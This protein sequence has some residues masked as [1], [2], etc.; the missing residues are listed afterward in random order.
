MEIIPGVHQIAI[1]HVNM[2]LIAEE[3]LTVIDTRFRGSL[4]TEDAPAK[5][6]RLVKTLPTC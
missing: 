4:L 5:M 2:I 3:E 1:R 6:R